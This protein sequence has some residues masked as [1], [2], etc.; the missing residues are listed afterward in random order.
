VILAGFNPVAVDL[1]CA[2][3]MGFDYRQL[4][5]LH[6]AFDI[7]RMPLASF[8]VDDVVLRSDE[9]RLKYRLVELQGQVFG[10]VPHFGWTGKIEVSGQ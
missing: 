8:P 9:D 6:R 2:R 5:V 10:F 7:H 1:A 3:L 4:P